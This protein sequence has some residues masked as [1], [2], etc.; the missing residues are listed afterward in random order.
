MKNIRDR[1]FVYFVQTFIASKASNFIQHNTLLWIIQ[2][3]KFLI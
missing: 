1:I 3:V 2:G